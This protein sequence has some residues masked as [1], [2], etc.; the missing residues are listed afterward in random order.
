MLWKKI[1][2]V[3][4]QL[5]LG[6]MT[7]RSIE[8]QEKS[9]I[10]DLLT[11]ITRTSKDVIMGTVGKVRQILPET[12]LMYPDD[13]VLYEL[14]DYLKA[15]MKD[16]YP[17]LNIPVLDPYVTDSIEGIVEN[18]IIGNISIHL[19]E[20]NITKASE[21]TLHD[22]KMNWMKRELALNVT[23]PEVNGEAIYDISGLL[24]HMIPLHGNGP[25]RLSV[26]NINAVATAYIGA[27]NDTFIY[28]KSI[29]L[30]YSIERIVINLKNLMGGGRFGELLNKVLSQE[31]LRILD[32]VKSDLGEFS[33]KWLSDSGNDLLSKTNVTLK[34]VLDFL[35]VFSTNKVKAILRLN[36]FKHEL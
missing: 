24:G 10:M 13:T 28:I 25:M 27:K 15:K 22:I 26:M 21:F 1:V 12:D 14:F 34:S 33:E 3:T 35:K 36:P 17:A 19:Q 23:F 18:D 30:D 9:K 29:D 11:G 2:L 6:F 16:P 7:C 8:L 5:L 32:L 31:S 20:V 4:L